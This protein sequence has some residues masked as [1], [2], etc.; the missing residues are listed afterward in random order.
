MTQGGSIQGCTHSGGV[1]ASCSKQWGRGYIDLIGV[2]G[3]SDI[4]VVETKLA[5]NQDDL[6]VFQGLDYY[7]WAQAYRDALVRRLGASTKSALEIHY[8]IGDTTD[9]QIHI[10]RFAAAQVRSLDD[11]IRWRFQTIHNWYRGP[12]TR[13]APPRHSFQPVSCHEDRSA[14]ACA[15]WTHRVLAAVLRRR[16]GKPPDPRNRVLAD[17]VPGTHG[18]GPPKRR[19][20]FGDGVQRVMKDR[21]NHLHRDPRLAATTRRDHSDPNT[22]FNLVQDRQEFGPRR[23]HLVRGS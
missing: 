3:H 19:A 9:G 17:P 7:I 18:P 16:D 11:A 2:D 1:A 20:V 21:L 14:P 5:D 10:S 23:C 12:R 15:H 22:P 13:G 8:V 6:L 4:R